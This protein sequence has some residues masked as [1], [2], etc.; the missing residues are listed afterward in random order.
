MPLEYLIRGHIVFGLFTV[1]ISVS[2]ANTYPTILHGKST[3]II[4]NFVFMYM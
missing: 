2:L 4:F 3:D 1:D